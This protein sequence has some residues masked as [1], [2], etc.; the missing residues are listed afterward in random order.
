MLNI[1][2]SLFGFG[3]KALTN[4]AIS[5]AKTHLGITDYK[6]YKGDVE[7]LKE[8]NRQLKEEVTKIKE[9]ALS[10]EK[11]LNKLPTKEDM[12]EFKKHVI[13]IIK[14]IKECKK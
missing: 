8:E 10:L 6:A 4:E 13:E 7:K 14:L 12:S 5:E 11:E 9:H 2:G 1:V 3:K